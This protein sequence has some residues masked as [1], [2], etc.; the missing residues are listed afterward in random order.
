[1]H[2]PH[3]PAQVLGAFTAFDYKRPTDIPG[4]LQH[5]FQVVV[6]DPPYLSE[7]CLEK[8]VQA[9]QL[10]GGHGCTYVL[11]TGAAMRQTAYNLLRLRWGL[12]LC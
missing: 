12:Q 11:L 5:S 8:T 3:A 2:P 9:M 6:A 4:E 10:L 7:E 1:M